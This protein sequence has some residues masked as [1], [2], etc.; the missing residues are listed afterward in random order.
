M[1]IKKSLITAVTVF[2]LCLGMI[3]GVSTQ[4]STANSQAGKAFAKAIS[5]K[6]IVYNKNSTFSI[7]DMDGDGVKDLL[8]V[9]K[10]YAKVFAYK[11]GK[12][13]R[14]LKYTPEYSL[15]YD[16]GKK[17][18]WESGEG[19]GSWH[20]AHKL[21]NGTLTEAYRYYSTWVSDD[22]LKFY[23]QKAGSEAE[24]ITEE[25]YRSAGK[26]AFSCVKTLSRK[27]LINKLNDLA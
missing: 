7:G 1:K 5:D 20:I 15:G 25:K 27:K 14:I 2:S 13:K 10:M 8:I 12:I 24:E 3:P 16:A 19:E 21:K 22:V 11:S 6:K 18:F 4:A 9:G 17:I 23:Y 26:K